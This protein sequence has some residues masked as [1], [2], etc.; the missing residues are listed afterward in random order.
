M[1]RLIVRAEEAGLRLDQYLR[2]H[3]P[4]LTRG[5]LR[6]VL[7]AEAS[8]IRV[9]GRPAKKGHRLRA[10]ETVDIETGA[11]LGRPAPRA[12]LAL[13]IVAVEPNFVVLNKPAGI[14]AHP[15]TPGESDTLAG[16]LVARFPECQEASPQ[17]REAGLVHRLDRS[18]SG[19]QVA[20]RDTE[21]YERMRA[22]FSSGQV[23]KSYLALVEGQLSEPGAV[24]G[25]IEAVPGDTRRVRL[26]NEPAASKLPETHYAPLVQLDRLTLIEAR[27]TTGR[28]HQVRVHLA[29]RGYPLLGD[30]LYGRQHLDDSEGAFLH[31]WRLAWDA[32]RFSVDLP[33]ERQR[34]V[35]EL[36][37]ACGAPVTALPG[38]DPPRPFGVER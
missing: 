36:A 28:R 6:R 9:D 35:V 33:L 15:L 23:R 21:T 10:G 22:R 20:A 1:K 26:S 24:A 2:R 18:T 3:A 19:L 11:L 7:G 27:C 38:C 14:H 37:R 31:A 30:P 17:P 32:H 5:A 12:E 4:E 16:R 29:S 13:E 8:Q 25:E 34:V